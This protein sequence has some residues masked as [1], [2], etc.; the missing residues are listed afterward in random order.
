VSEGGAG[1]AEEDG[2][3][4]GRALE[5]E[6][7][8]PARDV[9]GSL[10]AWATEV[11][12]AFDRSV[13]VR[14]E[15]DVLV[16]ARGRQSVLRLVEPLLENAI[17]HG[18]EPREARSP[19]P[20]TGE[21]EVR[22]SEDDDGWTVSVEDDGRGLDLAELSDRARTRGLVPPEALDRLPPRDRLAL[23]F[24]PGVGGARGD[25][26]SLA[27]LRAALR[28]TEARFEV[29]TELGRG[30]AVHVRLPKPART[31]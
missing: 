30:T 25:R 27:E 28:A 13:A 3:G 1:T 4:E 8:V 7:I 31:G 9:L 6:A 19:K 22:F 14:V 5:P 21:I 24:V 17:I 20:E 26:P 23:A 12:D 11:A 16:E 15:G 2:T 18:I 29:C 10:E